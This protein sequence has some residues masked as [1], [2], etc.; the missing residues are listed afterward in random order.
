[1]KYNSILKLSLIFLLVSCNS[2]KSEF[3]W[4]EVKFEEG[5]NRAF[6]KDNSALTGRV[7]W[8]NPKS[9][10]VWAEI[11]YETGIIKNVRI[12]SLG[13]STLILDGSYQYGLEHGIWRKYYEN[14]RIMQ[15]MQFQHGIQV[16]EWES[17]WENGKRRSKISYEN[18]IKIGKW[19]S[20]YKNEQKREEIFFNDGKEDGTWKS[21]YENGQLYSEMHYDKGV[22]TGVW[23][24]WY[25]NGTKKC[26]ISFKNGKEFGI[27]KT[28]REDGILEKEIYCSGEKKGK[29]YSKKGKLLFLIEDE[30]S[31]WFDLK[32]KR[33]IFDWE[34]HEKQIKSEYYLDINELIDFMREMK[35]FEIDVDGGEGPIDF[36]LIHFRW[37]S[38]FEGFEEIDF[39][40][41]LA[42]TDF[43]HQ[44]LERMRAMLKE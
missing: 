3:D 19:E 8:R 33:Y 36:E 22:N 43:Q 23:N 27:Y 10:K 37:D 4:L 5:Y 25:E 42:I 26:E 44:I 28:W 21:W 34:K 40:S 24:L 1:M 12:W 7:V 31:Y 20:W 13:D 30:K 11:N 17:Q 18:G 35:D 41:F 38:S 9:N 6:H 16:G 2:N 14:K 32:N 29:L 15:K 39:G